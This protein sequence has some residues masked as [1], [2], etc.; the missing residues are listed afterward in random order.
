MTYKKTAFLLIGIISIYLYPGL[1]LTGN[2]EETKPVTAV[3]EIN[4][5][6]INIGDRVTYTITV[7]AEKGIDVRFPEFTEKLAG[8]SIKDFG[9]KDKWQLGGKKFI[10]WY[11]LDTYVSGS[12]IIPEAVIKYKKKDEDNWNEIKTNEVTIEVKS[13]LPK[14]GDIEDIKDIIG[15]VGL[16]MSQWVYVTVAVLLII[17]SGLAFVFLK[18]RKKEVD[19]QPPKMAHE[20]ACEALNALKMKDYIKQKKIEPY[21]VELSD[22]IRHY[23]EDQ[24]NLKAPEMTTEEFLNTVKDD[25]TLSYDHKSLLRDFL[26]HCDMVKFARYHPNEKEMELVYESAERLIEQTK[27]RP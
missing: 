16:P 11:E 10:Q 27:E 25:R 4:R 23:L 13:L 2:T 8:F 12:Y 19:I 15:P 3:A 7:K 18:K 22:I 9:L 6:S 26:S 17:A 1:I 20:I 5:H 24:F 14:A 21:Y